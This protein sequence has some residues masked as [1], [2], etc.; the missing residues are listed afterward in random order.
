MSA[1]IIRYFPGGRTLVVGIKPKNATTVFKYT[2]G[3]P[4]NSMCPVQNGQAKNAK[5]LI[6]LPLCCPIKTC[7]I[8]DG[9]SSLSN[10]SNLLVDNGSGIL[11]DAGN[12][13][14][15]FCI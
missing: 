9:G 10:F 12:S 7:T 1:N 8:Y 5:E 6:V 4:K 2:P 15:I 14:T 13:Y 11:V 3:N